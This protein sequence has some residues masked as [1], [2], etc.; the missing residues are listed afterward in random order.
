MY[1]PAH[2]RAP[3]GAVER[4]LGAQTAADLVTADGGGDGG[5]GFDATPVPFVHVPDG[6]GAGH[7]R[8]VGHL[9]RNNPQWRAATEHG[10][11]AMVI[12]RGPDAYVSPSWYPSKREHGRAVPTWN[13]VTAHVHGRL[14]AHDDA[15]WTEWA[16]R[17]LTERHEGGRPDPWSVDDAPRAFTEGMLRA[18]V[19][20]EV[21]IDRIEGKWKL[22]QN[23]PEADRAGTVAGLRGEGG[24]QG[25]AVAA[26]AERL[27]RLERMGSAPR[28]DRASGA[29]H[30][31]EL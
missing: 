9:A 17:L 15:E 5:G 27:E 20:I 23:R 12:V 8:L 14:I 21:R 18:I 28:G 29:A 22:G 7:G 19:G 31:A 3:E 13:Y 1:V 2:F 4:L 24:A 11:P 30:T 25:A 10:T 16:V 6:G 26:E